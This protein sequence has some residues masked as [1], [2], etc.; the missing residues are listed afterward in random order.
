MKQGYSLALRLCHWITAIF[1]AMQFLLA[2]LNALVYTTRPFA[3]EAIIQAHLS[4]GALVLML[5][6][7]RL[8]VKSRSPVPR[9]SARAALRHAAATVQ[10]LL[11]AGLIAIPLSGYLRLAALDFEITLFGVLTLPSLG[12]APEL[13]AFSAR[14]HT[15]LTIG[16]FLLLT[17]HVSAAVTH[18]FLD[19][20]PVLRNMHLKKF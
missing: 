11:Y 4:I 2:L 15:G 7:L 12:L 19:G 1:V 8:H 20:Q 6:L 14:C 10:T 9:R 17:I 18:K 3:A 16:F 13:A 5:T